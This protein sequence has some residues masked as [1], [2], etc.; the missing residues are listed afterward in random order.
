MG[1]ANK[2]TIAGLILIKSYAD[3]K[4]IAREKACNFSF[5]EFPKISLQNLS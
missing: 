5:K 4:K 2:Q 1:A 3:K